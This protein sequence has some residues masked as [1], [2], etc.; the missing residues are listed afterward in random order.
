[1][2]NISKV[3]QEEIDEYEHGL[4]RHIR[5]QGMEVTLTHCDHCGAPWSPAK[6]HPGNC[7]E[8][9]AP[10]PKGPDV[11]DLVPELIMPPEKFARRYLNIG[12]Q[13]E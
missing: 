12:E 1:M 7:A 13:N 4:R 11:S 8:C 9:G 10:A 5:L 6:Y 2:A 3:L